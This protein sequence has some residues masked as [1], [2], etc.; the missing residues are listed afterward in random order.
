MWHTQS[1]V[2]DERTGRI[3]LKWTQ[4]R[5]NVLTLEELKSDKGLLVDDTLRVRIELTGGR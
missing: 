5:F 3:L 1:G 2:K 4:C